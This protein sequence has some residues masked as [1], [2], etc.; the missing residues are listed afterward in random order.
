MLK[1]MIEKVL[2][3]NDLTQD[4]MADAV[5]SV[6]DGEGSP[7]QIAA[8][9][10]ALR[11]K[12]EKT[13]EI[14]GAAQAMRRRMNQINIKRRP[15]IDT[16]GTGGSGT[17]SFNISTAVAFVVASAEVAVAK[18][19]NKAI[20]SKSGSADVLSELGV[21]IAAPIDVMQSAIE[22][23]GVGF[24]FAPNYHPAMK[25]AGAVRR[26]L[27]LRTIFNVLG[28]L[29]NP[30]G[31][32]RQLMGIF[33]KNLTQPIAE[34]LGQLGSERAWVVHGS[35]GVDELTV[36]GES[37]VSEWNGNE[38]VNH[39]I[40]PEDA[41]LKLHPEGSMRGGTPQENASQM[42]EIF[43]GEQDGALVDAIALNAG[44]AFV[45]AGIASD[46]RE[47][48]AKANQSIASGAPLNVLES[49]IKVTNKQA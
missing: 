29:T 41:G 1:A 26:E 17:G 37:Y 12:G 48:V 6:M 16:C 8:F 33:D 10:V 13:A 27:G 15:L 25:H 24:L 38:V 2:A 21:N 3:G 18:H 4:E 31:A 5:G 28:P 11:A 9:L 47:G 35:D 32:P 36:C 43:S 23:I 14:T 42:R 46:L 20:S 7:I 40:H 19:G 45:V 22:D 34:V 44:A 49:L 30:A 39:T